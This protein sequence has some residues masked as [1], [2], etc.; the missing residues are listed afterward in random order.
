MTIKDIK[1]LIAS[2]ESRTMETE[3]TKEWK[4]QNSNS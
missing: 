3:I 1:T 2:D 4:T